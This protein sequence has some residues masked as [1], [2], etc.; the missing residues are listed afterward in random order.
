MNKFKKGDYIVLKHPDLAYSEEDEELEVCI[1]YK[2]LYRKYKNRRHK[3]IFVDEDSCQVVIES[4][5]HTFYFNE[6]TLT[7]PNIINKI[8]VS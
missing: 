4:I 2:R 3:I 1:D 5:P 7:K 6:I 8:K